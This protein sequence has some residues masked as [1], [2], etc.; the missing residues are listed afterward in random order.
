MANAVDVEAVRSVI[1]DYFSGVWV[2]VGACVCVW[3]CVYVYV[4][5][6]VCVYVEAVR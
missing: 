1:I 4:Y 3:V 6:Y 5:V 2:R